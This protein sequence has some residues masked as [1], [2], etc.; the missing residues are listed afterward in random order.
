MNLGK[1]LKRERLCKTWKL[2]TQ[3][4]NFTWCTVDR[5]EQSKQGIPQ[6]LVQNFPEMVTKKSAIRPVRV[7]PRIFPKFQ[8]TSEIC[9]NTDHIM[10]VLVLVTQIHHINRKKHLFTVPHHGLQQWVFIS[11]R[12]IAKVFSYILLKI[13]G[14][15]MPHS[16]GYIRFFLCYFFLL[17]ILFISLWFQ[18][19]YK[20]AQV[21]EA[22]SKFQFSKKQLRVY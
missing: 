21:V 5:L 19:I 4:N 12:S 2:L 17:P 10:I 7:Q 1:I 16:K 6:A 15:I 9:H 8:Q 22:S 20:A 3:V 18:K 14:K 13:C 11:T